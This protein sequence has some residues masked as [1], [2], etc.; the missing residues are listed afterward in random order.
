VSKP[1][2]TL[3]QWEQRIRGSANGPYPAY[4]WCP[5]CKTRAR[6]YRQDGHY[7]AFCTRCG[8]TWQRHKR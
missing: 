1:G 2:E 5:W 6:G 3:E 8:K 7:R 4:V